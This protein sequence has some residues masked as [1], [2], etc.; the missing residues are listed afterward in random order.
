VGSEAGPAAYP[1]PFA[2]RAV[3]SLLLVPLTFLAYVMARSLTMF[4]EAR[5]TPTAT[6]RQIAAVVVF[7]L[8]AAAAG[9]L[10]IEL[11]ELRNS[12]RH[13]QTFPGGA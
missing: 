11:P 5:G 8:A 13:I 6:I 12:L 3:T 10:V 9:V 2:S 1:R 4:T 7:L